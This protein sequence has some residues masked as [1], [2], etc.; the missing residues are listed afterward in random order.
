MFYSVWLTLS[1]SRNL[2]LWGLEPEV[3][4]LRGALAAGQEKEGQLLIGENDIS[5]DVIM[6]ARAFQCLFTFALVSASS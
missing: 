5:N 1:L 3:I 4:Q 2:L 6:T